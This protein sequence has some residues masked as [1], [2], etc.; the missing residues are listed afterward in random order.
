MTEQF[1]PA[2]DFHDLRLWV[3]DAESSEDQW[4]TICRVLDENGISFEVR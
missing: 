4:N 1:D 2:E 3:P